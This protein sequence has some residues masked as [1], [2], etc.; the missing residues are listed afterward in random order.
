VAAVTF[1]S[2]SFSK[3]QLKFQPTCAFRLSANILYIG[4][5][6]TTFPEVCELERF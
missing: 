4:L 2:S 3:K 1:S 6:H 5:I